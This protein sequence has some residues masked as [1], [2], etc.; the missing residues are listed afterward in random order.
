MIMKNNDKDDSHKE[1]R[2][3]E[4]E[5]IEERWCKGR[6]KASEVMGSEKDKSFLMRGE[7]IPT[8]IH[9]SNEWLPKPAQE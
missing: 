8:I 5:K 4:Q 9:C 3:G 2:T 7:G 6:W 1:E